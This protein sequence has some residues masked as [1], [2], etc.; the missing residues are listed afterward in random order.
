MKGRF[1]KSTQ[2]TARH[3]IILLS[4]RL[5]SLITHDDNGWE[6]LQTEDTHR[7]E[8]VVLSAKDKKKTLSFFLKERK[9]RTFMWR[10]FM[11]LISPVYSEHE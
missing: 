1:S 6:E 3:E 2:V 11:C 4:L 8:E 10:T 5:F 7:C 9:R